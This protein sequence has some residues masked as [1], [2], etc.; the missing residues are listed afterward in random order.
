MLKATL[1]EAVAAG[2]LAAVDAGSLK[3]ARE[4]E[5]LGFLHLTLPESEK[6]AWTSGFT[7]NR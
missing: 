4:L 7:L 2:G 3:R 6:F 1:I 5:V